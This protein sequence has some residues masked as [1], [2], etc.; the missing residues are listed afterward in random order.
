MK[1]LKGNLILLLTAFIWGIAFVAQTEGMNYVEPFTFNGIR[2]VIGGITLLPV[3]FFTSRKASVKA[4]SKKDLWVGGII[5]GILLGVASS[6]QQIGLCDPGTT[7]GKGGFI[8]ALYIVIVPLFQLFSGKKLNLKT[9]VAIVVSLCGMYLLCLSDGI[10]EFA[11]GDLYVMACAFVFSL[12]I[13]AIDYYSPKVSG[14]ALSCIQFFVAGFMC[15]TMMFILETPKISSI[16]SAG[17]PILYAGVLSC[18]VAY[19]LQIIGQKHTTPV[20]ATIIMSLESVFA[21]LGGWVLLNERMSSAEILGAVMMFAAI[22]S[23]QLPKNFFKTLFS[24]EQG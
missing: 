3:V 2:S 20:L 4:A 7:A 19:T 18:G 24:K 5:C 14:V 22:I 13:L 9:V 11:K 15:M 8:T 1:N 10:G 21:A 6:L 17:V 16:L 12:H 23:A